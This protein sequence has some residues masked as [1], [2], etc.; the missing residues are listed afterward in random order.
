VRNP[1]SEKQ[2]EH[3]INRIRAARAL[4]RS[5]DGVIEHF[6][7]SLSREEIFLYYKAAEVL[8]RVE[9]TSVD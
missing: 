1:V 6:L 9:N 7:D 8:D 2:I 4:G 3:N 5:L